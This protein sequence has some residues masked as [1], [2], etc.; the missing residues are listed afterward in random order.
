M[1]KSAQEWSLMEYFQMFF[2]RTYSVTAV[3]IE[4]GRLCLYIANPEN[5]ATAWHDAPLSDFMDICCMADIATRLRGR[6]KP[7]HLTLVV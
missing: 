5:G 2:P 3:E 1:A 6:L 4:E 7:R